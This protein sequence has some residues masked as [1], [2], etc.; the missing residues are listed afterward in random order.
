ME[1]VLKN[2]CQHFFSFSFASCQK[3]Y[4]CPMAQGLDTLAALGRTVFRN[5]PIDEICPHPASEPMHVTS[6][7]IYKPLEKWRHIFF[8]TIILMKFV[9]KTGAKKK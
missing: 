4:A 6:L 5:N 3:S 1:F 9:P 7:N 2:A 8:G